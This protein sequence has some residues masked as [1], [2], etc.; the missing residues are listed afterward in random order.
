MN[1]V[2]KL[3]RNERCHC[4]S[5]KKYKQCCISTDE[6]ARARTMFLQAAGQ[7]EGISLSSFEKYFPEIAKNE[8]RHFWPNDR[9][10]KVDPP[11]QIME[12]YCRDPQC[13]CKRVLLKLVDLEIPKDADILTVSYA[14]D[15]NDPHPG[16][17]IDLLNS[18]TPQGRDWFPWICHL[19]QNDGD[20]VERLQ[21][22]Y[23][24]MKQDSKNKKKLSNKPV[25]SENPPNL[26]LP[27]K[28]F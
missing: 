4:G 24:M 26:S 10:A 17:Y 12:F 16:P 27:F 6:F 7:G 22:H 19:L 8:T 23:K 25:S 9:N 13:D 11:I 2:K 3:E 18:L 15:R 28:P 14:F 20:Y 5:G 1:K 21:R